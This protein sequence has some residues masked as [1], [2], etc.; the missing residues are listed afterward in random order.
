MKIAIAAD[1]AG[2][3]IKEELLKELKALGHETL[4]L[5]THDPSQPSDYPDFAQAVGT[6]LLAGK[7]HRGV[8]VCG[9]GVGV[10]IAANKIPGVLAGVCHDTYSARQGV[11]HDDMNV[12]CVGQRVIGVELA[13]EVLRAFLNARFSVT[14]PRHV[15]R[16]EKVR[17]LEK[18]Y[19]K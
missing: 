3:Q 8:I 11:E 14:E 19:L 13:K 17:A 10:C 12:L 6:A 1:H 5:G 7:V 18:R 4:D 16:L 2:F 15:A 9:S